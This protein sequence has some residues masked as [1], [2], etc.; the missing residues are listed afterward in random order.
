MVRLQID[1]LVIGS[2]GHTD[3]STG[4]VNNGT[5]AK[6]SQS[7]TAKLQ[8]PTDCGARYHA[9]VY[10][11]ARMSNGSAR[12]VSTARTRTPARPKASSSSCRMTACGCTAAGI[13]RCR[14][15][16]R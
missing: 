15:G 3:L 2:Q 5:N 7:G 9:W 1:K 14:A 6:I 12:T 4:P 8:F 10:F 11:S 16:I 13:W